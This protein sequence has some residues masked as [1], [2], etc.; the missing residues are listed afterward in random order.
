M[1]LLQ[2]YVLALRSVLLTANNIPY[3][4][5][6]VFRFPFIHPSSTNREADAPGQSS[7]HILC[8]LWLISIPPSLRLV[9]GASL[10]ALCLVA[11]PLSLWLTSLPD[12]Y[13]HPHSLTPAI[14]SH[15]P[16]PQFP[17]LPSSTWLA[18]II[19]IIHPPNITQYHHSQPPSPA[20][21]TFIPQPTP[22]PS[23]VLSP[24]LSKHNLYGP[25]E[26]HTS[27]FP[28]DTYCT[29]TA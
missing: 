22:T 11:W 9:L 17:C 16:S 25:K 19:H 23:F 26:S 6:T 28:S 2:F 3:Y 14:R 13:P 4:T 10:V 7:T 15:T 12:C 5:L 8:P 29:H 27:P 20:P 21:S 18:P 1:V 24:I